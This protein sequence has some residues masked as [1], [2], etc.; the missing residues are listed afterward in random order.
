MLSLDQMWLRRLRISAGLVLFT[1]LALHMLM[2]SLGNISFDAMQWGTQFHDFIW[3]SKIGTTLFY[4]SLLVHFLLALWA[5][6][7]RDSLRMGVGEW[8][9]LI[10]GF[11]ILPLMIHHMVSGRWVYSQFD[12]Q[13]T[14]DVVLTVY[15][16]LNSFLG[17]RQVVVLIVAWTHGCLGIHFWL[18]PRAWYRRWAPVMLAAAVVLPVISL[19]GIWQGTREVFEKIAAN[20]EWIRTIAQ[21]GRLQQFSGPTEAF[22]LQLYITFT[23]L[24]ALTIVA[25]GVRRLLQYRRGM[26]DIE[27]AGM[28]SVRVPIGGCVLDASRRARI[29]HASIC[30]GRGRCTTCRVRVLKGFDHLPAPQ[31]SEQAV[32]QRLGAGAN[33]RLACQLR[34]RGNTVVLPLLP[35]GA[36]DDDIHRRGT[37]AAGNTERIVAI[38]F[39]DIR[40]STALAE[41]RL[42]YDVVFLLNKFFEAVAG[43]V[44]SAGGLPNQ[45]LGDGMMALFGTEEPPEIGC[46][47]ALEAIEQINVR[48]A[49]LN[50]ALAHELSEPLSVGIGIHVGRVILGEIGYRDRC[51]LT[52]IGDAVHVAARLQDLTK[53]YDCT[54]IVSDDV[55][56]LASKDPSAYPSEHVEMRGR[57]ER[58]AVRLLGKVGVSAGSRAQGV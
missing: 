30:G 56:R 8:T 9:R 5:V 3:L 48:L 25:R 2:H 31:P 46:L 27:F 34:P 54:A 1:Y 15:F 24:V 19:L 50:R 38:L 28:K 47:Q 39:I 57:K 12:V 4:G 43:A 22:K 58:L 45:F 32:L 7:A 20:P 10:L 11:T 49:E 33:V 52:A 6:Y 23:A 18:K 14:Y 41:A 17:W 53:Q 44:T 35:A 13:R 21:K 51:I 26:I 40:R 37:A 55:F 29:P 36:V 16:K 42:P